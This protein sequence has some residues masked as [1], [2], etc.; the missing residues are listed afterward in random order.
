MKGSAAISKSKALSPEDAMITSF[1]GDEA[2]LAAVIQD[3][4][5]D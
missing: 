3:L 5:E 1:K 2:P 4:V